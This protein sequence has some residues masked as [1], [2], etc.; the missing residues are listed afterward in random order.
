VRIFGP[1]IIRKRVRLAEIV[2]MRAH[3]HS[4]VV[5]LGHSFNATAAGSTM[6]PGFDAVAIYLTRWRKVRARH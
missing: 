3:S 1:G 2:R 6:F 5:W 4:L